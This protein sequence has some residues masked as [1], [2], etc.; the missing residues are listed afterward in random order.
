LRIAGVVFLAVCAGAASVGAQTRARV[1]T[2]ENFRLAPRGD[3]PILA[4]VTAGTDVRVGG[5]QGD[6]REVTL[7][8]WIWSRSVRSSSGDFDVVVSLAAG[9]NLRR[10]PNGTVVARLENGALLDE[11]TRRDGW[12]RVRRTAWMWGPSLAVERPPATAARP[13]APPATPP[14]QAAPRAAPPA[15]A[16]P[17]ASLDRRS[18]S[19]GASLVTRP[20]GD[21]V[22]RLTGRVGARL[23][24]SADG[25]ARVL[26]EAWVRESDLGAPEDS[27][28][29]GVTASEV[30]GS[31][32]SYEGR[33]LRWTLQFI[34]LQTADE[35]R[36]DI[37]PGRSYML[38]RGPLPE[39]GFVYVVLTA[40]QARA[41]A[42]LEPLARV[43]VLG[44]VRTA[45]SQYLGNPILDLIEFTVERER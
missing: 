32:S 30:R 40:E 37:P 18:V 10:E 9:E 2:D 34:A 35:L 15:A 13:P 6:W 5:A 4:R 26:V 42:A 22:G 38:A 31:G 17:L 12:V 44:R 1:T 27:A 41:V 11:V 39:T 19:P 25:W 43:T 14:P 36:R 33:T 20:D 45:R 29:A 8:G 7:E 23:V 21:T 16:D 3:A 24:T 28:L